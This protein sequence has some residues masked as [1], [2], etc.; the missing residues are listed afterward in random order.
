MVENLVLKIFCVGLVQLERRASR[1][2][3]FN[4]AESTHLGFR[5]QGEFKTTK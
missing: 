1:Y 3:N 4:V 5:A 2:A